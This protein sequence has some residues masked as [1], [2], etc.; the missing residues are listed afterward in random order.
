MRTYDIASTLFLM[1]LGLYVIISG[2]RLGFGEWQDP[3]PGFIAVLSGCVLFFLSALWLMMTMAKKWGLEPTKRFFAESDSYKRVLLT[4]V[5][6]VVFAALLN[7]IGFMIATL[8]LLIFLFRAIDPQ[9][10]RLAI[11]LALGITIVCVIV[12]QIWLQV[13]LP[14]GPFSI[15]A[16]MRWLR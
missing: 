9:R 12:F 1:A 5:S 14:E 7:L 10:W 4:L 3:G 16:I 2:V 11:P 15:Y 13:Q 6:L 8:A